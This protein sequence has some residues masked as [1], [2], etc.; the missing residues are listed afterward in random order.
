MVLF[1]LRPKF[2]IP[3]PKY[4]VGLP[5]QHGH[6]VLPACLEIWGFKFGAWSIKRNAEIYT[7]R[8][9]GLIRI[10]AYKFMYYNQYKMKTI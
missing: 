9:I 2:Q 10:Y 1:L 6:A 3:S 5:E 7:L 4:Q 8:I